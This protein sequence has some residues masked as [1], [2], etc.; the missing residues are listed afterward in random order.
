MVSKTLKYIPVAT[1]DLKV[2]TILDFDIFIQTSNNI[3]LFRKQ[4]LPFTEETL[5][6]LAANKVNT[7]F[8]SEED[9]EKLDNYYHSLQSNNSAEMS[10]EVFAAP[11]DNPNNVEK[12]FKTYLNYYPIEKDN[13]LPGSRINFKVYKKSDLDAEF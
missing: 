7:I 9:R 10:S 12:Y 8:I 4:N 6:N 11:F 5:H 1:N 13:L 2:N 3:V